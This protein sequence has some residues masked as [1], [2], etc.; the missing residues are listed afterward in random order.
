MAYRFENLSV[1][2]MNC[3]TLCWNGFLSNC[4]GLSL[5][6]LTSSCSCSCLRSWLEFAGTQFL[7]V[8]IY[9]QGAL[10]QPEPSPNSW[11]QGA[12]KVG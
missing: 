1:K 10:G 3:R 2:H 4:L 12:Q 7:D 9:G 8:G 5:S 6:M 11:I